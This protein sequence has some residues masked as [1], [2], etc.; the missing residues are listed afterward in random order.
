MNDC[1][2]HDED[3]ITSMKCSQPP[4]RGSKAS[5]CFWEW[6]GPRTASALDKR[7]SGGPRWEVK[8]GDRPGGWD[9]GLR[10]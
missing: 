9:T 5:L 7:E 3:V 6:Q 4:C 8:G 1:A 2:V 10:G